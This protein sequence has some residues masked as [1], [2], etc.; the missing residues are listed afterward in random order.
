M[1]KKRN[2]ISEIRNNLARPVS[3]GRRVVKRSGR[4]GRASINFLKRITIRAPKSEIR[5]KRIVTSDRRTEMLVTEH[6]VG[7]GYVHPLHRGSSDYDV[8]V[9]VARIIV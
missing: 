3:S 1:N 2:A 8:P 4:Y 5:Q 7:L 9:A 6:G